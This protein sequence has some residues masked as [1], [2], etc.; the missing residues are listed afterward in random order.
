VGVCGVFIGDEVASGD[1]EYGQEDGIGENLD[2]KMF[3]SRPFHRTKQL[4]NKNAAL[5]DW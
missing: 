3:P 4:T 1:N 2:V 5:E